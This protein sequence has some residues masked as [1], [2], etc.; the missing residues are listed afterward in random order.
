MVIGGQTIREM[1][2]L[3]FLQWLAKKADGLPAYRG[4]TQEIRFAATS[5]PMSRSMPDEEKVR[6][7]RKLQA[8]NV[9]IP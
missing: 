4:E 6:L 2:A 9:Q 1:T 8:L 7:V 5:V 3:T